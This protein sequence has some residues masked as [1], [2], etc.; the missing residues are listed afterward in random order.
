M[1]RLVP[2]DSSRCFRTFRRSAVSRQPAS[3][4]SRLSAQQ[5]MR[6]SKRYGRH[7]ERDVP[8]PLRTPPTRLR[9]HVPQPAFGDLARRAMT[10][11]Q[12]SSMIFPRGKSAFCR[13]CSTCSRAHRSQGGHVAP[14]RVHDKRYDFTH[15][16]HRC[17][18]RSSAPHGAPSRFFRSLRARSRAPLI[19]GEPLELMHALDY[20]LTSTAE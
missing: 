16:L 2:T 12:R 10:N 4:S 20:S 14:L 7:R 1:L 9:Q 8:S 6:T 5:A 17:S 15:L 3:A 11:L 18:L 19:E 13:V